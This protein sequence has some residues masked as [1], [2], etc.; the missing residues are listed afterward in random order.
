MVRGA[1]T[2]TEVIKKSAGTSKEIYAKEA[3]NVCTITEFMITYANT[4]VNKEDAKTSI[5]NTLMKQM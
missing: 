2:P 3:I 1:K 5:V 4:K